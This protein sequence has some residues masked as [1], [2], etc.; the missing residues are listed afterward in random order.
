MVIFPLSLV[1]LI[2]TVIVPTQV[3]RTM[4]STTYL[5]TNPMTTLIHL[6]ISMTPLPQFSPTFLDLR[7][8]NHHHT[9]HLFS[10]LLSLLLS[11]LSLL[12]L[13]LSPLF[14]LLLASILPFGPTS[15][16]SS[17]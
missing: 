14:L 12:S 17:S 8:V 4:R 10:L 3:I 11:L 16:P 9:Y 6:P 13:L 2:R 7:F 15:N 1:P 5:P